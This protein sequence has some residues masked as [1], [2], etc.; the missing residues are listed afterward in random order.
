MPSDLVAVEG[1][2]IALATVWKGDNDGPHTALEV[3]ALYDEIRAIY[4]NAEII[5]S[6]FDAFVL[7]L[8]TV[9]VTAVSPYYFYD[10]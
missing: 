7:E 10:T 2:P 9:A 1:W 4:P 5:S 8:E 6:S 3:V